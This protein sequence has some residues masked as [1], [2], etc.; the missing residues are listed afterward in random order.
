MRYSVALLVVLLG[1]L[2]C[3]SC[4]SGDPPAKGGLHGVVA[5]LIDP[6]ITTLTPDSVPV[7]SVSFLMTVNGTDFGTDATV[8]FNGT[9]LNTRFISSKQLV[10]QL[11]S[12]NLEFAGLVPVYVRT[13]GFNSNTVNFDVTIQ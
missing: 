9:P 13:Q 11:Q 6:T 4:G 12:A 5:P 10:A 3:A 8:F 2:L 1:T 7:D